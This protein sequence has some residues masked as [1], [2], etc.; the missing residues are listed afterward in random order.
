M[1]IRFGTSLEIRRSD[2]NLRI[3][4]VSDTINRYTRKAIYQKFGIKARR[5][6]EIKY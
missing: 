2:S 5:E 3:E 4:H 6:S 1:Q